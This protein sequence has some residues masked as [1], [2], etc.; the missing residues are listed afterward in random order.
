M[1]LR[2]YHVRSEIK[3]LVVVTED[4]EAINLRHISIAVLGEDEIGL[5]GENIGISERT[6]QMKK[7]PK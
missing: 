4:N 2:I 3:V 1:E 6:A 7:N 5:I